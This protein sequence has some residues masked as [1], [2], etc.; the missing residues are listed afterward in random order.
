[1]KYI[2]FFK[3]PLLIIAFIKQRVRKILFREYISARG[4]RS[5]SDD[6]GLY[7]YAVQRAVK[8]YKYFST[9]KQDPDYQ[10]IL[11]HVSKKQG[12]DY[13]DSVRKDNPCLI[14]RINDFK[15]NDL[16]GGPTLHQYP[17]VGLISPT[18]LRYTKVAS[19]LLK[20]FG[21]SVGDKVVEIGAGYGGQALINDMTFKIKEYEFLDLPPVLN[22]VS[23]YLESH[24]LNC[25]YKLSTLNQKTGEDSYDLVISNYAF[26]EL[27][28]HLQI[29]YIDKVI[30]QCR[31]GYMTMNSGMGNA[32]QISKLS[33]DELRKRLPNFEIFPEYPLTAPDNYI[34][35]W[36]HHR[37]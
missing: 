21:D 31:R 22:L 30:N 11:E 19:D 32:H 35:V 10:A 27:P 18:T 12:E 14:N 37:G 28:T 36:G 4:N 5:E 29:K 6:N 23:K 7:I 9:F 34:I 33:L 24:I 20:F 26:S 8:S 16:V 25:G 13:L 15:K 3:N 17:E 1:M 2:R